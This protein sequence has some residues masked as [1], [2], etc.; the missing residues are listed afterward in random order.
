MKYLLFL[1]LLSWKLLAQESLLS[2]LE[3]GKISGNLKYYY[4]ETNKEFITA[5]HD[6]SHSNALGA[7]LSYTSKSYNGLS[8]GSTFMMTQGIFLPNYIESSTIGQ[9]EGVMG[10]DPSDAYFTLGELYVK[11]NY[12]NQEYWYGRKVISNPMI[13]P[14]KSRV[15][16]SS[17]EGFEAIYSLNSNTKFSV[18]NIEKFKQRTAK[19]F[20]NIVKHALGDDM[21]AI[22]GKNEAS[23]YIV[24]LNYTTK[25]IQYNIYDFYAENF[26]NTFYT[27]ITY[28]KD[29]YSLSAQYVKQSSIG[30]AHRNLV[31]NTSPTKGKTIDAQ[32]FGL[33]AMLHYEKSSFDFVYR[34]IFR[35]AN[36]YDS[37]ITPWDG[38]LL[39]AYSSTTN[40]LGQSLYGKGLTAGGAYVG[41]TQG[42]KLGYTQKY[43]SLKN[44][45]THL[46]YAVYKNDLY[47]E[48]QEDLR[49]VLAYEN[50]P[51]S[52]KLVGIWIDNDTYTFK[53]GTVNQLDW[54]T[55]YHAV[56][57]YTF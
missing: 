15:L 25:D 38:E 51:F 1:T 27:D 54:L 24:N 13:G 55:Q 32:G 6:S 16:P 23:I 19:N 57:N 8:F 9:D 52:F 22:T 33:R 10:K 53:D 37:L 46:A 18:S 31:Q 48:D 7:Q 40:N 5:Q 43:H 2:W 35:N 17:I 50:T 28:K 56:I 41:G 4:I 47:R 26:L 30:N 12:Q 49:V 34:N 21:F 3:E 29:F 42:F 45:K 14:K 39:Y 11:Y 36:A 44:F 20:S